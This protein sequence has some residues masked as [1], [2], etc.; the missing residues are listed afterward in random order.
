[1]G[2]ATSISW[3]DMTFNPWI[4][5]TH[6]SDAC[7]NCYA[8]RDFDKRKHW[9]KW[10]AGNPRIRTSAGY[11]RQPLTW[12]ERARRTGYRPRIFCA[13]L[14]DVFDNEADP[15]WRADL[16]QLIRDT[17]LLHWMLLTK[18]IG[19]APKMLPPDWQSGAFAHVGLMATLENQQVWDRDFPK[20]MRVPA[21]WHGVSI[22]PMLGPIDI[23]NAWLDWIITGGESGPH[24]RL[25]EVDWVRSIR[26][27]CQ[28]GGIAFHH[29]QWGGLR[30]KQ[31]GCLL[32]GVDYKELP[33]ALR[34]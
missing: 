14:A 6:V 24:F 26:D 34:H 5:C 33:Q 21:A 22:E 15:A 17:P 28:R 23:G 18:R 19:N 20:L 9:A 1:M 27:Q 13:S 4:G 31:N 12:N 10:G 8:E 3:A 25:T 11:W 29:K 32:D 7:D 16:W 30:S 2:E